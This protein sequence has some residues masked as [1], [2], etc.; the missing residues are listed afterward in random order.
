[1]V[2][3]VIA[4]SAAY[5]QG[6][7]AGDQIVAIDDA[8]AASLA[9]VLERLSEKKAGEVVRLTVFR[10]DDLRRLEIKLGTRNPGRYRIVAVA[11]PTEQQKQIYQAWLRAPLGQ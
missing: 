6:L 7:N 3:N 8:R 5:E 10:F 11:Q 4:G 1:M 2:R 9:F